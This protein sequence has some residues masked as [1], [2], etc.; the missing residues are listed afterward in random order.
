M[1]RLR[2]SSLQEDIHAHRYNIHSIYIQG[3]GCYLEESKGWRWGGF[4]TQ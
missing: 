2:I 4:A 1:K 3:G